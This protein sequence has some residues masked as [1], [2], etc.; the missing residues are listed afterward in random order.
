MTLVAPAIASSFPPHSF[1]SPNPPSIFPIPC[2]T[3]KDENKIPLCLTNFLECVNC[4]VKDY[5]GSVC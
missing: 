1:S 5:A 3:R 4:A 2:F